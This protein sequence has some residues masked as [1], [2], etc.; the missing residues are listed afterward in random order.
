MKRL[1]PDKLIARFR[2]KMKLRK[3]DDIDK[4]YAKI[5]LSNNGTI[6]KNIEFENGV[7]VI[8]KAPQTEADLS[9]LIDIEGEDKSSVDKATIMLNGYLFTNG[10]VPED[11]ETIEDEEV[12][13]QN[14]R[15]AFDGNTSKYLLLSI[16]I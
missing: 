14:K 12:E 15:S 11:A 3:P 5:L 8:V 16:I 4:D 7:R 6:R 10:I 2:R 13:H 1:R 9:V